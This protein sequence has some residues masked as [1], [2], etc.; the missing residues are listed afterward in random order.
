MLQV[1]FIKREFKATVEQKIIDVD[2]D[3]EYSFLRHLDYR[4]VVQG[5]GGTFLEKKVQIAYILYSPDIEETI[6]N[7][8]KNLK[9]S[10]DGEHK[11]VSEYSLYF[12]T[13]VIMSFP[14]QNI[15]LDII[16]PEFENCINC[17]NL[18]E[19]IVCIS[20]PFG[21]EHFLNSINFGH[22][23]NVLGKDNCLT[24]LNISPAFGCEGAGVYDKNSNLRSI[25]LYS[26][27][28]H[29]NENVCLPLAANVGEICKILFDKPPL[30]NTCNKLT[31]FVQ[32]SSCMIDS[33][34]CWGTGC[35]FQINGRSFVITCA[36]VLRTDNI[37]CYC[38]DKVFHPKL[39]YKNPIFDYAFD[40][41]LLEG[42]KDGHNLAKLANYIP[43]VGQT[44][45][46]VGFPVFKHFGMD[47]K[48][49]PS[50]YRGRVTKYTK[51]VINTDCPVQAGQSGGPIFDGD[52]NLLAVMVSNFKNEIDGKIYPFHNMC[53]PIC[54]IYDIL[55]RYSKTNDYAELTN[56]QAGKS[57]VDKWKLRNPKIECKL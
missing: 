28:D 14:D 33:M 44:V 37:T 8:F 9:F 20:S 19:D 29:Q 10:L 13:F 34:G 45:Y 47:G 12:S 11:S 49:T 2:T 26:C 43:A 56:L 41:A 52:G 51:G 36:H 18:L 30:N 3:N 16:R 24:L 6:D 48:F 32:R 25:M 42:P 1:P 55:F 15:S 54:D 21:N 40:V 4:L 50:I 35:L 5:K 22:V 31:M 17:L 57:I 53:I 46:S 39:I 27:F 7:N 38:Y 23:A